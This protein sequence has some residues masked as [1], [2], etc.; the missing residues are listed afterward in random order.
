MD[1]AHELLGMVVGRELG[2]R[3]LEAAD[4]ARELVDVV[5]HGGLLHR[6]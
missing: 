4:V 5:F 3:L 2:D 6:V 1:D